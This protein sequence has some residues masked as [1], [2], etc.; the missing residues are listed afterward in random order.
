MAPAQPALSVIIPMYNRAGLI[1]DCLAS[2]P[3]APDLE[4]IIV[5]DGSS[6]GSVE[7]AEQAIRVHPAK[8]HM[9]VMSQVNAGPGAARNV[10]ARAAQGAWLAFLDCDDLWAA[11][12]VACLFA[13]ISDHQ[14]AAL[15]FLQTMDFS[16]RPPTATEQEA[17]VKSQ[18]FDRFLEAVEAMPLFRF[19]SCNLAMRHDVFLKSGGFTTQTRCSEDSDL[20]LRVDARGPVLCLTGGALVHHRVGEDDS[21]S[22]DALGVAEGLDFM[23]SRETKGQY[24]AS[25][26]GLRAAFLSRAAV[27]TIRTAFGQGRVGLAYRLWLENFHLI[28]GHGQSHWLWRLPLT[29]ILSLLRPRSYVMRWRS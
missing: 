26:D 1:G 29:P 8:A 20:F 10:G 23:M 25:S 14:D 12:T 13:A 27:Y 7:A 5:D 18:R 22:A 17:A 11:D 16:G 9:R 4:V 24:G 2:L 21:L 3:D 6:D 15:I 19:A 28:R